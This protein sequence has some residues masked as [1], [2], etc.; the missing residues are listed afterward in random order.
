MIEFVWK[1][2]ELWKDEQKKMLV[3]SSSIGICGAFAIHR[4]T[5]KISFLGYL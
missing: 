3:I 5:F 1:L 4:S 2:N